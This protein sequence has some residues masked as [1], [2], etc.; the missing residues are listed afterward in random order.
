MIPMSGLVFGESVLIYLTQSEELIISPEAH[1]P[2]MSNIA[3]TLALVRNLI[4]SVGIFFGFFF[5]F[6]GEPRIAVV[7]VAVMGVGIVG[8]IAFCSHD[9]F[10]RSDAARLGWGSDHPYWQ[11]EVGFANL[12]L[13]VV[14][15]AAWAGGWGTR[16]LGAMTLCFA[17]YLLQAGLLHGRQAL[18]EQDGERRGRAV[19]TIFFSVVMMGFGLMGIVSG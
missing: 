12:S 16:T 7:V 3:R 5:L 8:L 14:T 9:I 19:L 18:S 13:A 6:S 2:F 17:I 10:A 1:L 11:Y 4:G 15:L